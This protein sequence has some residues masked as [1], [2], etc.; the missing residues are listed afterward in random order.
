MIK[1]INQPYFKS[2]RTRQKEKLFEL[3]GYKKSHNEINQNKTSNDFSDNQS[4]SNDIDN[5]LSE[6]SD[7][8][9]SIHEIE[10]KIQNKNTIKSDQKMTL[11][12]S[13]HSI[14]FQHY[15]DLYTLLYSS[16]IFRWLKSDKVR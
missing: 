11:L 10:A 3:L 7:E 2:L 1:P 15:I 8:T 13:E 5:S 6:L 4:E 16:I 14:T 12:N 9:D